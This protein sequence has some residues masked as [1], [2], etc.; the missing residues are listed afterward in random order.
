ME[1][2]LGNIFVRTM[3]F[4]KKGDMVSGHTHNFDHVTLVLTG[5]VRIKY[6]KE[7]YGRMV[8]QGER[9]FWAPKQMQG[10]GGQEAQILIKKDVHHEFTALED[11]THCWCVFSHRDPDTGEVVEQWNGWTD[12]SR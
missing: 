6:S 9:E 2:V 1:R 5:G 12:A 7:E 8:I 3:F 4:E 10:D 11:R